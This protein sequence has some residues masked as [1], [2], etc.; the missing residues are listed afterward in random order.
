MPINRTQT[1]LL[2]GALVLFAAIAQAAAPS[3]PPVQAGAQSIDEP[4]WE[5][6]PFQDILIRCGVKD[7][8]PFAFH[9]VFTVKPNEAILD[10]AIAAMQSHDTQRYEHL[11]QGVQ[12]PKEIPCVPVLLMAGGMFG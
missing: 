1:Y 9:A 7:F 11:M 2:L 6:N 3:K 12:C 5:R 10:D 8:D 4:K